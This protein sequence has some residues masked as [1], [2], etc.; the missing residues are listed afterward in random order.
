MARIEL[1]NVSLSYGDGKGARQILDNV[2]LTI[3]AGE[4][5]S[6]IGPSGCGKTTLLRLMGG[7]V[8]PSAGTIRF[9]GTEIKGPSRQR[10]VV[11]Q[12]YG[13]ALL[14]WRSVWANVALAFED[15]ALTRTQQKAR[16]VELLRSMK[17]EHVSEQYPGQLSGGMQQRVQI[18]RSLAQDP[19]VLLMDEP[20][21][22][23]DAMT[24]QQLQDE[25]SRI[26]RERNI[27]AVF[28]T[29]DLEEAIYLGD[30]VIALAAHPGRVLEEMNVGLSRPRDQLR[31]REHPE[32]LQ[33]RHKLF[34][35]LQEH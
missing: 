32:F 18:A 26:V 33:H 6:I 31:T 1:E 24:R 7:L 28:I 4:F 19:R 13:R 10:A 3:G 17:L 35:L 8:R 20:F 12:D 21:G 16:S 15:G 5:V 9:E 29:H 25:I 34:V 30:R 14:P 23:L 27:T 11:F 2:N 22:A